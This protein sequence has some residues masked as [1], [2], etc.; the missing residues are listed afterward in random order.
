M[1]LSTS[2]SDLRG[3]QNIKDTI[4]ILAQ[5]GFDAYD[6][7]YC[8][9]TGASPVDPDSYMDYAKEIRA[10]AD[11]CGI[12]C[13]QAHAPFPSSVGDPIKDKEIFE[14]IVRSIESAAYLGAKIIVVH[15]CQHLTYAEH[16]EELFNINVDF[17]SRLIPYAEKFSIKIAT[18][19]MWQWNSSAQACTDSTCSRAWEFNKYIDA[20]SSPY[21]VGCLDIGHASLMGTDIPKFIHE[22]GNKRIQ[23]LHVHETDLKNDNHTLPYLQ[24]INWE[25]VMKALGEIDYQGDLTFESG[26]FTRSFPSELSLAAETFQCQVGRQLCSIIDKYRKA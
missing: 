11:A 17:Y 10:H 23:A 14:S 25:E 21:L 26:V 13:N 20:L 4:S 2:T 12:V 18:E 5:A 6:F 15:P 1:I 16:A 22:M 24:K 9:F 8:D 3:K 19:N 7:S